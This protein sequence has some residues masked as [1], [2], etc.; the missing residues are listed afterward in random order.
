MV[1]ASASKMLSALN[2]SPSPPQREK[3]GFQDCVDVTWQNR[4]GRLPG[5]PPSQG[6]LWKIWGAASCAGTSSFPGTLPLLR[7]S[8]RRAEGCSRV[9]AGP[10][11][12]PSAC[13]PM[14]TK[15]NTF[16]PER[17]EEM[18]PFQ[19]HSF[20]GA[21]ATE[22]TPFLPVDRDVLHNFVRVGI[23]LELD[24]VT[25]S[26]GGGDFIVP[27]LKIRSKMFLVSSVVL[28]S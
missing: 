23:A 20:P 26:S 25:V 24:L 19:R 11:P 22:A 27:R 12:L 21:A 18:P 8:G 15:A 2:H 10:T 4:R 7:P 17:R 3:R 28:I 1:W 14:R 9:S 6:A 13:P 16:I 5:S